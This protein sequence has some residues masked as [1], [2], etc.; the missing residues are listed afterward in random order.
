M[1]L[2]KGMVWLGFGLTK[3]SIAVQWHSGARLEGT[4]CDTQRF[5]SEKD[6]LSDNPFPGG[7]NSKGKAKLSFEQI[8]F[9][10]GRLRMAPIDNTMDSPSTLHKEKKRKELA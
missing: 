6:T 10:R 4:S 8:I 1:L 7:S 9:P 2:S 5:G 3:L